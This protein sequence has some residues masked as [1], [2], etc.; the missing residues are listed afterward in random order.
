MNDGLSTIP[1]DYLQVCIDVAGAY[2]AQRTEL[3]ISLTAIGLLWTSTDFIVKGLIYGP[4]EVTESVQGES[5]KNDDLSSN[6]YS[7]ASDQVSMLNIVDRDKLLILIFTLLQSLGAD[8]RPE[9]RNSAV[10][11]LF[12]ILGS[13]GQKLSK[14]MWEDCL[15]NY[16]F[17][18]LER[19]SH[20]VATSSK[21]EWQGK[22]LGT[23]GG[24]AV[25]MLIHHSRNTAQKQWDETLVLILGGIA[26]ILRSFFPFLRSL[27]NFQSGWD[28]LL[29]I[30]KDSILNGSKEVV[31]AAINCLQSTVVSHSPKGN[32]PL[33][34]LISVLSVY[35]FALQKS[36]SCSDGAASKVKQEIL[37][38]LGELYVQAQGMFDIGMYNQ[39]LLIF[40]SAIK[41]AKTA[42]NNFEAEYGHVPPV[43]RA[44]LEILPLLRPAQH[45]SEMWS[46]FLGTLL[47]Y[48]PRAYPSLNNSEDDVEKATS[49]DNI[50]DPDHSLEV[51]NGTSLTS[52]NTKSQR[53][54]ET[55][56]AANNLFAEKLVPVIIDLFLQTP[57]NEKYINFPDIVQG[58]GRCM[59]TRRDHPDGTLWRLA[60]EGFNKILVDNVGGVTSNFGLD[61]N[62]SKGSRIR[63]WKEVADIYEVFLV[64]YCGR[65]LFSNVLS[66]ASLKADEALEMNTL[67]TLGDKIL[68]SQINIPL[69]VLQRLIT[70]LD[71]CAS[72]T[73]TLP[74][75]TV[76]LMP[77]HCSRFSLTCLEKLFSLSS[78]EADDWNSTRSEVSKISLRILLSRCELILQKFLTDENDLGEQVLPLARVDEIIFVLQELARLVIHPDTASILP[79]SPYLMRGFMEE[80]HNSRSHLLVLF[81][82]FCE[83]VISRESRV[84]ELVQVLLRLI[85]TDLGLQKQSLAS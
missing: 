20:M 14:S 16:V 76:E 51:P 53:S 30:V 35:E 48:L 46:P 81:P 36:P 62:L 50:T 1:A 57:P 45:L 6:S 40:D 54:M 44:T 52:S 39:M 26:R 28:S 31:L 56:M 74:I 9:V 60:I 69:D 85:A 79:L 68:K 10:R 12:Q 78:Y 23:R 42:S 77:L 2:G 8:G 29:L 27:S 71:Q 33:E 72:R 34:Y 65:A 47:Q 22:E 3:N 84:R 4:K 59:T 83:L 38:G 19:A 82:S 64:G 63:V 18:T 75:E 37:Q 17:P 21:D 80:T 24:K 58:L 61:V 66:S 5:Q 25:H 13:H 73:S 70:T 15:W 32:L 55:D 67:G 49:E 7:K 41:Q 11:T 43:Q